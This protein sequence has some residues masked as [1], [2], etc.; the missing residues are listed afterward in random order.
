MLLQ[1]RVVLT[2]V[3]SIFYVGIVASAYYTLVHHDAQWHSLPLQ[4]RV[5]ADSLVV[6]RRVCSHLFLTA[7]FPPP[8][9]VARDSL[10]LLHVTPSYS[11]PGSLAQQH[12]SRS[13][14]QM[15]V[16]QCRFGTR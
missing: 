4:V 5:R 6:A 11:V 10:S 3:I 1:R 9:D 14:K 15:R 16:V 7:S 13:P 12:M 8:G 2:L